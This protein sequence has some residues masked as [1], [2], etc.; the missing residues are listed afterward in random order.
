MLAYHGNHNTVHCIILSDFDFF[1]TRWT[2]TLSLDIEY[3]CGLNETNDSRLKQLLTEFNILQ[4]LD[5][6]LNYSSIAILVIS[7]GLYL[8]ISS[9]ILITGFLG[10]STIL[11]HQF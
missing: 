8:L 11:V 9:T 4:N 1:F 2:W 6:P 3:M 5:L 7:H 10:I